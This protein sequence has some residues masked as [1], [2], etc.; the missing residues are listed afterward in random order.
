MFPGHVIHTNNPASTALQYFASEDVTNPC[1]VLSSQL[2]QVFAEEYQR[3]GGGAGKAE[4]REE[5]C[6]THLNPLQ[7]QEATEMQGTFDMFLQAQYEQVA[8]I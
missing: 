1:T 6:K 8:M 7:L 4:K 2:F 3:L 5:K